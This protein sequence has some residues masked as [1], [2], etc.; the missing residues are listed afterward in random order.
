MDC[1]KVLYSS[2]DWIEINQYL[3]YMVVNNIVFVKVKKTISAATSGW[4][5]MGSVPSQYKPP[6]A[7]FQ[8]L[9]N[10]SPLWYNI[11][12]D[13]NGEV[14]GYGSGLEAFTTMFSYPIS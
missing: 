13:T 12:I 10:A 14:K 6:I 3:D 9:Y 4:V 8:H 1:N 5:S 11:Q 2:G 7:I